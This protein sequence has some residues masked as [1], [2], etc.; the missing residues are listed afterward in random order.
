MDL[1]VTTKLN[2][3]G[4][5][6][7]INDLG[8]EIIYAGKVG[9]EEMIEYHIAGFGIID[10]Y[11]YGQGR[12]NTINHVIGDLYNLRKKLEHITNPAHIVIK[13]LMNSMYDETIIKPVETDTIVKYNKD[14]FGKHVS[15]NYTHIDS[16]EEVNGTCYTKSAKPILSHHNFVHCG[17]GILSMSKWVMNKVFDC[18]DDCGV[19]INIKVL[20]VYI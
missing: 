10:G 4:V 6:D 14:G 12:N 1:P 20:I 11:Y 7:L 3:D 16:I 8:D 5:R 15:Y 17:V 19:E 13:L 2:E 18:A 9:L